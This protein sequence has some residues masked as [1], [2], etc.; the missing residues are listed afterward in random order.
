MALAVL[1]GAGLC[2]AQTST[3][4]V[5]DFGARGDAVQLYVNTVSNSV[6]V[7]TTN[8]LSMA[9]IGKTIEIFGVGKQTYGQNSYG[10]TNYGNQDLIATIT[11]VV[12][13]TNIYIS[14]LAAASTSYPQAQVTTNG[15][16]A[17]YGTDNT[18]AFSNTVA[19]AT[20]STNAVINIPGGKYLLMPVWHVV[21][22]AF[23][24]SICIRRG[25]LHFLGESQT[26]TVLL[27]RGAWQIKNTQDGTL[28]DG[29]A[30]R[31]FLFDVQAP[32]RNKDY[33]IILENLT[34]DGGVQQGYLSVHGIIVNMVDGLGWD[35]QH[36]AFLT[37]DYGNNT[38]TASYLSFTNVTVQHWR[39][40]MFK[41]IDGNT[42]R[43]VSIQNCVF[44]DGC[45]T[46]L[47]I[48]GSWNVTS[49]VF[50]DLF[51]VAEYYQAFYTNTC[52]FRNNVCTNINYNGF[53]INGASGTAP[54]FNLQSNTFYFGP[55]AAGYNMIVFT[56]AANVNVIGNNLYAAPY[57][58][59]FAV[60]AAGS[61]GTYANSNILISGNSVI[62]AGTFTGFASWGGGGVTA[63]NGLT[64]CSNTLRVKVLQNIFTAYSY[65]SNVRI[66][67]NDFG[68][69][70]GLITISPLGGGLF[71]VIEDNNIYTNFPLYIET[72][73]T[74]VISYG[75]GPR[76]CMDYV[77]TSNVF[78]LNDSES[79]QIPA[80]AYFEID[81]CSNRW[82]QYNAAKGGGNGDIKIQPSQSTSW[83]LAVPYGVLTRFY[84][85]GSAWTTNL[86]VPGLNMLTVNS[87][88]G[89]GSY[90]AGQVVS[91]TADTI[92]GQKFLRWI[93]ATNIL[94]DVLAPTTTATIPTNNG[95]ITA[96]FGS[97]D[98]TPPS[99]LRVK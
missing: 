32:V 73:Q 8:Q 51:S 10:L 79:N 56:P 47:N 76:H 35:Q 29:S 2:Q 57:M 54:T 18:A 94:A 38:G 96:V 27:S 86:V 20:S 85:N 72:I 17:T 21:D 4:T 67:Y 78:I 77:A 50:D 39:G 55:A 22:G 71:P 49:N 89:S 62:C 5:T 15:V 75:T 66:F 37:S 24:G 64:I 46:A 43:N 33:P 48:Y 90:V 41:S 53:S 36:S 6:V 34:L 25:G 11:N 69:V 28:Y 92:I 16:F 40:E 81:N 60:G 91:V 3:L 31:G 61:Q 45:A 12:A 42:N 19:A 14:I 84:W 70:P 82:A 95:T 52:Y 13:A 98:L 68:T 74:N 87:G 65:S 26:N 80:G 23:Y 97:A 58:T 9:D 83:R 88:S 7:T 59:G 1:G 63:V 30:F 99:N 93:G 44:R